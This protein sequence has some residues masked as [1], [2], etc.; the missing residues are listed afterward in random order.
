[1]PFSYSPLLEHHFVL[2]IALIPPLL[3]FGHCKSGL[4]LAFSLAMGSS[5]ERLSC[6]IHITHQQTVSKLVSIKS[7]STT[8][9]ALLKLPVGSMGGPRIS[10]CVYKVGKFRLQAVTE[11]V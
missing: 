1:M 7:A 9:V 8:P 10:T 5:L 11:H 4:K 2:N 6:R 3:R